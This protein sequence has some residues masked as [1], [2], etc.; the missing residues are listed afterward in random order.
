MRF[1]FV[2]DVVAIAGLVI[3]G[4]ASPDPAGPAP[5]ESTAAPTTVPSPGDASLRGTLDFE[6][7]AE[8]AHDTSAFTQ[9]LE[10]VDG[11]LVES[12]GLFGSS[13]RRRVDA[14]TGE[15]LARVELEPE[16]FGEGIT[17][18]DGRLFQLT[19]V[20]GRLLISDSRTL[21]PVSE[22]TY[23][24]EGWGICTA[25]GTAGRPFVVSDGSSTLTVREPDSFAVRRVIEVVRDD[26]SPVTSLNELECVEDQVLANVWQSTEIV[27]IDLVSGRVEASIDLA[28]IVPSGLDG[29]REVLNGIA[30]RPA[31]GTFLVTG[32][33]WP[34]LYELRLL[35]AG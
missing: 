7:I 21:Q 33:N 6:V 14:D 15:V 11:V 13:D 27:V 32:K 5:V 25:E 16:L 29:R 24:G 9:G 20:A 8:F 22:M 26:G 23:E 35:P 30:H 12:T 17:E 2:P 34:V 18:R 28:A 1:S 3:G 4:C 19:W 31:T 10:L